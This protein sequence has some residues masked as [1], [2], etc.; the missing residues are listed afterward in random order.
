M[1]GERPRVCKGIAT[2]S[3]E[4]EQ[5]ARILENR[6]NY[7]ARSASAILVFVVFLAGLAVCVFIFAASITRSDLSASDIDARLNASTAT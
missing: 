7:L 2:L 4:T 1:V 3:A 5:W 6:A